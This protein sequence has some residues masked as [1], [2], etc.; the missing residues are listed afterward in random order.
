[1]RVSGLDVMTG[2]ELRRDRRV[3]LVLGTDEA[4]AKRR[5]AGLPPFTVQFQLDRR[6]VATREQFIYVGI[7]VLLWALL[8]VFLFGRVAAWAARVAPDPRVV[9]VG[10]EALKSRL[11]SIN[12][13]NVPFTVGPGRRPD[14]LYVD[15]RYADA[16]WMDHMRVHGLRRAQRLVLRLDGGPRNV[17]AMERW[18]ALDWSAGGGT[19]A[20]R[21]AWR[22]SYGI[23]FFHY[24]HERVFG[25]QV[26]NGRPTVVPSYAYTFNLQEMKQPVI[27]VIANAGWT[28]RPVITFFRPIGG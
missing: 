1:V 19:D 24:A 20:A 2:F 15:W 26:V 21:L 28:Y 23:T 12:R 4:V 10:L 9:P 16:T 18:S 22:T 11:M 5:L 3:M 6:K 8:Q 17:R 13:L 14:E 27:D 25:L 7:G